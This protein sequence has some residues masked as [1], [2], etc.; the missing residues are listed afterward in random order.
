VALNNLCSL[1]GTSG[2]H[3]PFLRVPKGSY[4]WSSA[5]SKSLKLQV[6]VDSNP[7]APTI[8]FWG[9]RAIGKYGPS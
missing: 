1:E 5:S 2:E 6:F 4:T 9:L 7:V 3:Y 8:V